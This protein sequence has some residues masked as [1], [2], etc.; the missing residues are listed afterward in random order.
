MKKRGFVYSLW[1]YREL[2][3]MILPAVVFFVIFSYVP[4]AG[5]VLAFKK[6][7]FSLGM[8][9][10]PGVGFENFRFLF[11]S[12]KLFTL[13]RNTVL[14]NV[15]FIGISLLF[16]LLIAV[17]LSELAGKVYKK[18]CQTFIFL[19]YF[20]SWVVVGAIVYN[21][22]N[23]KY[24]FINQLLVNVGM[25]KINF[26]A[27]AKWWPAFLVITNTWKS[28][29]Y[30]SVVYLAT[31]TGIDAEIHEA[32]QIDGASIVQRIRYITLPC[33]KPTII[34]LTLMN[35]GHVFQGNFQM[36]WNM[37]G[38]NSILYKT[39]DV[40]D[41]YVYRS[42]LNSTN[43]GMT[44][45]AGMLQSVLNFATIVAVNAVVKKYSKEN[46]LF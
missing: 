6:Y 21:L 7:D 27:D 15:A 2:L 34:T 32:A 45:A 24:G 36:F 19:P 42:M 44:T 8:F 26:Y 30:G 16:Q 35:L 33:L 11:S 20:V 23:Y 3:L 46:A 22:L 17:I 1:K 14:Y 41:T 39:T 40:I 9:K 10:S 29:G 31:I 12:G 4:M 18:I 38:N 25:E 5:L 37:I 13:F 43:Y 28:I